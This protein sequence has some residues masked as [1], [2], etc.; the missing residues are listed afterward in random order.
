MPKTVLTI[1]GN[2]PWAE[3]TESSRIIE[4]QG[5]MRTFFLTLLIAIIFPASFVAA[6]DYRYP[7]DDPYKATVYGT[8]PGM[9]HRLD[10][11]VEAQIRSLNVENRRIPK[12]FNYSKDMYYSM[13][14]QKKAAELIFIIAGTGAEHDSA[15][16][17]F[18]TQIFYDAGFH[19][20]ALS[21]PTHMNFVVSV[22]QHGVPGYVPFDVDDLYRVMLWIKGDVEQR[23]KV[24]GYSVTGYSLGAMHTAFLAHK[25]SQTND[26]KFRKALMI[27]PP[28]SLYHSVMRLDSWLTDENLGD[29]SAHDEI[30]EIIAKFSGYYERADIT[31]LDDDFLF[32][33]V[34][35][36]DLDNKDLRALIAV[37]FRASSSSMIF[38]SDVCKQAGYL[39][40]PDEYPLDTGDPLLP[41]AEEAFEVSF[42][43][44]MFEFLLPYVQHVQPGMDKYT[45]MRQCSLYDIRSW[46][47][48]TDKVM[49]VGNKDDV[50]LNEHDLS[51]I[52]SVFGS[53]AHLFP[54]G[55]HCGNI[56]YTPFVEQM[57]GMVKP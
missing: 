53:R 9:V 30:E 20:I 47:K 32:E 43:E 29:Q 39:V 41:Y 14:L 25:D 51:F 44:Y 34:T 57:L 54:S 15:K 24:T 48:E 2:T 46:L 31:D 6:S 50:I 45:L 35:H 5:I 21:S 40:P 56:M 7:Y 19:V 17:T 49:V 38:A 1:K 4:Q 36:V 55:G 8:P 26:F 10:N 22:S 37:D 52:K 33:L 23:C 11:P 12:I 18:L 27:N 42:E 28:V 3:K 16:M 13:A